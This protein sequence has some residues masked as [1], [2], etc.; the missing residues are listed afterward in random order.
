V[1]GSRAQAES[2]DKGVDHPLRPFF[3]VLPAAW[4]ER[5]K[6]CRLNA[7]QE[8]VDVRAMRG[9]DY[10]AEVYPEER[11]RLLLVLETEIGQRRLEPSVVDL[12]RVVFEEIGDVGEILRRSAG[13]SSQAR[14]LRKASTG[15]WAPRR[16]R[17][18]RPGRARGEQTRG[19]IPPGSCDSRSAT[20]CSLVRSGLGSQARCPRG[21]R[22]G[23]AVDARR[24]EPA[25]GARRTRR[26]AGTASMNTIASDGPASQLAG[27]VARAGRQ[28]GIG[29]ESASRMRE[30]VRPSMSMS[31]ESLLS[32]APRSLMKSWCTSSS[33]GS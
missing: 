7:L 2:R 32:A 31:R 22:R 13:R 14:I 6:R 15:R 19:R 3:L 33:A 20:R 11:R 17:T 8:L 26:G 1:R 9:A 27:Q 10:C 23:C 18:A 5:G 30:T 28:R 12:V 4:A 29:V 16:R 25:S 24:R 21:G